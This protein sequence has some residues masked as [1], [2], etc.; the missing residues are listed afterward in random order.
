VL[1]KQIYKIAHLSIFCIDVK[2]LYDHCIV[3]V[4]F[5]TVLK[6]YIYTYYIYRPIYILFIHL[7]RARNIESVYNCYI[8]VLGRYLI[9]CY[10][11]N[12]YY[13]KESQSLL[14]FS[15]AFLY[16]HQTNKI[17]LYNS[18]IYITL[19]YSMLCLF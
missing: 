5:M 11:I 6:K 7:T 15:L 1:A 14:L 4:C 16:I 8:E 12:I 2:C 17:N 13:S 9:L 19:Y 18:H 3:C 10:I